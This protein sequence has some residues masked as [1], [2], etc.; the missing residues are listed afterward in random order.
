MTDSKSKES[1]PETARRVLLVGAGGH[2][3]ALDE[4]IRFRN[5]AVEAP[6]IEIAGFLD[7]EPESHERYSFSA[8]WLGPI[9]GHRISGDERYM[10]AIADP[11]VRREV[12]ERLLEQGARFASFVH[13]FA[14]VSESATIGEGVVIAPNVT[15]GPNVIVGDFSFLNS[16]CS[17]GHDTV[18]GR[19]N[20]IS[21]NVAFSGFTVV[22]D[23]NLFGVN[24][25]TVPRV[26]I[27][28]GNKIAPGMVLD[29][30]VGD[31]NTIFY[32]Y[33]ERVIAV[34]GW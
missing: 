2:A 13:P 34:R 14:L 27:G 1:N 25:A 15:V 31:A 8:P 12:A 29:R 32:R 30:D 22:G 19:Y 33:K 5:E 16:R 4:H 7:D 6:P 23:E 24:S 20:T 21:P 17:L 18:L 10:I 3:A 28:S 26:K 9:D 11:T